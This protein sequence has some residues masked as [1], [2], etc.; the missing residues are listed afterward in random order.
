M[1]DSSQTPNAA[2]GTAAARPEPESG[3]RGDDHRQA[4]DRAIALTDPAARADALAALAPDLPPPLLQEA[5]AAAQAIADPA[6][7]ER[8]LA[9]I[10]PVFAAAATPASGARKFASLLAQAMS[11][12]WSERLL[13]LAS[14][15]L[16]LLVFGGLAWVCWYWWL[17]GIWAWGF[18]SFTWR[19]FVAPIVVLY[20]AIIPFV[21][22]WAFPALVEF[23]GEYGSLRQQVSSAREAQ[24]NIERELQQDDPHRLVLV[25][26]YSRE[27]LAEYYAIAMSQAQRSFRYCLIAMWLGFI[28]LIAGVIDSFVPLSEVLVAQLGGAP[29]ADA[30]AATVASNDLVLL[31]GVVIEFIAAAFLWVYRFSIRQQTYYYRRQLRL[32]NALLA[33]RLSA[34]MGND[35]AAAIGKIVERLLDDM[36][37]AEPTPPNAGGLRRLLGRA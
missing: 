13:V 33:H 37:T 12:T 27:M 5:F 9:A 26:S 18:D 23:W 20:L 35:R 19:S 15:V 1:T 16:A 24:R 3:R 30:A 6:A 25:L 7:R 34:D 14:L 8:T 2:S 17:L 28:V 32:H 10:A 31:T 21:A 11:G 36:D 4:L 22:V 29:L